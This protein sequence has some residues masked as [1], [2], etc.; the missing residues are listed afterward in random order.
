MRVLIC[1]SH[2]GLKY[3]YISYIYEI[4]NSF[5]SIEQTFGLKLVFNVSCDPV[6]WNKH[7]LQSI[8]R[9]GPMSISVS[10]NQSLLGWGHGMMAFDRVKMDFL[11]SSKC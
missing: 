1:L 7:I 6:Y 4:P 10:S 3:I 11:S 2:P 8:E 9:F 5:F